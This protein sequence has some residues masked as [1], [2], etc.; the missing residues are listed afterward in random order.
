MSDVIAG[1]DLAPEEVGEA[2]LYLFGRALVIRQER[3]DLAEEGVDYNVIKHNPPV[4]A[5]GGAGEAPTFV[6]PNLDVVY[7]EAWIAVDERTPAILEVPEIPAGTYY[8][9]QIVDEWAEITYNINDRTFPDHPHGT[10]A[11][12]LTGSDPEVPA[13][14]QRLEIP[15]A[16]AKLLARVEIGE[17]VDA[18]VELQHGFS[19]RSLGTP[20]VDP[21]I[22]IPEFT[23]TAP[24]ASALF[25]RPQLEQ[26]LEA[27]DRSGHAEHF[28]PQL[29]RIADFVS[30][31]DA[32]AQQID[33]LIHETVFPRFIRT[34]TQV[35]EVKN[36]WSSTGNRTGFGDDYKFRTAAN[37]GGI[38]W[39]SASEVIYY[40]LVSDGEGD[41]PVGDNTY[42]ISFDS[43]DAPSEH[44]DG[45]W[46][47]TLYSHPEVM[48][49]PNPA[50]KYS[51]SGRTDL[52]A[53]SDG[54]FTIT[55]AHEQPP[56]APEANWL[57]STPP[58]KPFALVLRL[59]LPR[60]E[61]LEGTWSP[62]PMK[63]TS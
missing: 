36:G 6:N 4:L 61:V 30:S 26:A 31:D 27:P 55:I 1:L 49:V 28:R 46:S 45:Y 11:L 38:W 57:P 18:A 19:V 53:D 15:S 51:V 12:C 43:A 40:V 8:T 2:W 14:A 17:D 60:R 13:G 34:L 25:A 58:G 9:A 24:L 16:K 44:V 63:R 47:I 56:E 41:Q 10:F 29:E 20:D 21:A 50:G 48:L 3:L 37:F 7:S 32:H 22:A 5:G 39:N 59:Y 42:A 33:A 62:P 23:N 52:E 54:S 35:G